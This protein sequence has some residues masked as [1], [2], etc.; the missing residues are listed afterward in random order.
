MKKHFGDVFV[1]AS[2][3]RLN[4]GKMIYISFI[5]ILIFNLLS[6]RYLRNSKF[7]LLLSSLLFLVIWAYNI[8][9]PD[10]FNYFSQY[11]NINRASFDNNGYQLLY[12]NIMYYFASRK[13]SFY[14]YRFIVSGIALWSIWQVILKFKVN[15]HIILVMYMLT[16]FF[17]DGVQIRNFFGLPFLIIALAFCIKKHDRWRIYTALSILLASLVHNGYVV[18]FI[19]L[20]VPDTVNNSARLVKIH[21]FIALVLCLLFFFDRG[22]TSIIVNLI[23]N[24]DSNRALSYSL[25]STNYGPVII[26]FLQGCAIFVSYYLYRRL[27]YI[28]F[29]YQGE[30]TNESIREDAVLL[31][32]IFWINI[33]CLYLLPFSF[34]QLTFYRL[35]RNLLLMN[36]SAFAIV[37]KY[38][39]RSLY[40]TLIGIGYVLVWQVT[41]FYI[42]NDIETIVK[43]F[44][45]SNLLFFR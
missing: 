16:Q 23:N 28:Q 2:K 12:N 42:L 31:K 39:R 27:E 37:N 21:A 43:P 6:I 17:L 20:L 41:E 5:M 9:G 14:S 29:Y 13:F 44:F 8:D 34:I 36:F 3:E 4:G 25:N 33:I 1:K 22:Y 18:Y 24:F 19:L 32:R 10:I 30:T 26:V 7:I 35:I 15:I 45:E 40:I 11:Q 38:Y